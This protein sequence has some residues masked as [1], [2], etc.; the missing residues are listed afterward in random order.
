LPII[1]IGIAIFPMPYGY[2]NLLRIVICLSS[3]FFAFRLFENKEI[4][5]VWM[6][7]FLAILYNP[8]IPVYLYEKEI[9]III[10][11]AT[12]ILFFCKRNSI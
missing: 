1:I 5:F 11:T 7:G 10:N 6:F 2:Y 12:A 8:I 9:W 3:I 4:I